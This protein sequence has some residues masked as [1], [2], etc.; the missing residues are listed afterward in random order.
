MFI[1]RVAACAVHVLTKVHIAGALILPPHGEMSLGKLRIFLASFNLML[2]TRWVVAG[3]AHDGA[4]MKELVA[5]KCCQNN[6]F[7]TEVLL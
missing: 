2:G 6:H 4:A 3:A 7:R 1:W 5:K